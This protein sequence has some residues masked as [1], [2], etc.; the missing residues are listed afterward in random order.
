VRR[1]L[2]CPGLVSGCPESVGHLAGPR[3]R[4]RREAWRVCLGL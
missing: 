1:G 4:G 3:G 2:T